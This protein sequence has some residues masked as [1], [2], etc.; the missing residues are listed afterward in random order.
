MYSLGDE[1]L[2]SSPAGRE[3]GVL[4]NSKLNM[5]QWCALAARRANRTLG[6]IKHGIASWSRE[7][8]VLHCSALCGLTSSTMCSLG[9]YSIRRT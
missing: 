7:V 4:V 2:G 6:C 5:R 1:R 8:T 9:H 3:L